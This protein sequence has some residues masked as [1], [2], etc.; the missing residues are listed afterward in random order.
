MYTLMNTDTPNDTTQWFAIRTRQD[1]RAEEVLASRCQEVFF[2]KESV[3]VKGGKDRVRALIPHVLFI[4]TT[5][6]NALA[7]EAEGR[8]NPACSIP[9]WIYRY[10]KDDAIQVIP[11]S[12][13]SLLRLLSSG[14]TGE[15][16]IYNPQHFT[17]GQRVRVI[18]GIFAGYEGFVKRIS[19]NRHVIVRIEGI[20]MVVLPFIHPDLLEVIPD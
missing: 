18:G 8:R 3:T 17:P 10:P 13:I 14:D 5:R 12:S 9:L 15:C 7:L 2:P 19:K 1:Y 16:R 11:P 4:R 6:D 20:C